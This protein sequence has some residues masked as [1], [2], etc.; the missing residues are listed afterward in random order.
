MAIR[1]EDL[2]LFGPPNPALTAIMN[3]NDLRAICLAGAQK[4]KAAYIQI[5]ARGDDRRAGDS[6]LYASAHAFTEKVYDTGI[7][8]RWAG[9]MEVRSDH[10]LPHN[11]GWET[12][13]DLAVAAE[14]DLNQV[15]GM[16]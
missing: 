13:R 11:F 16:I 10:I 8:S 5:V 14:N 9:V 4:M 15:L 7:G 6:P 2:D 3:G 1:D 12:E